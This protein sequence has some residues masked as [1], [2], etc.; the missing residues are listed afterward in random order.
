MVAGI[1]YITS[2]MSPFRAWVCASQRRS[3]RARRSS[4]P[5]RRVISRSSS[6]LPSAGALRTAMGP[7][8]SSISAPASSIPTKK[9][10]FKPG[11]TPRLD[12]DVYR[13]RSNRSGEWVE[14]FAQCHEHQHAVVPLLGI[15]LA[16]EAMEL[17]GGPMAV[18]SAPADGSAEDDLEITR[19]DGDLDRR[20]RTDRLCE[21]Q[22]HARNG[23][24][25]DVA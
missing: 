10:G 23:D 1:L 20:A 14:I 2:T 12:H 21:A 11:R 17:A 24:I 9:S 4:S 16:A 8:A 13:H 18:R 22:T 5:S 25:V 6:A 15:E 3:V 7:P 19:R